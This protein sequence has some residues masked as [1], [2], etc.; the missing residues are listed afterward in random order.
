MSGPM[1]T[2]SKLADLHV[3]LDSVE[4]LSRS[5]RVGQ[6]FDRLT[7]VIRLGGGGQDGLGEDVVYD[8]AEQERFRQASIEWPRGE[9]SL[10][11]FSNALDDISLFERPPQ[12]AAY[13]DY[14]RW[15]IEA[16]GLDLALRQAGK[17]LAE[18]LDLSQPPIRFV[19]S[20]GLGHPPLTDKLLQLRGRVP[21]LRFKLDV[22]SDWSPELLE[23]LHELDAVDVVDFKGA[24][25]GTPVDTAPDARL[26]GRVAQALP[27]ALLEDPAWTPET[28][29]ALEPHR[30]RVSWDAPIHSVKDIEALPF[31]P[32]VLNIKPSRF[33]TIERLCEAYDYCAG[34]GIAMYGGGQFELDI[35]RQQIQTLAALF[36]ADGPNDVS[37]IEY[38]DFGEQTVLPSSPFETARFDTGPGFARV[39]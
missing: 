25:R 22:N 34:A 16:A 14:R 29:A 32:R 5:L 7:T 2:W 6:A 33:G 26:Y 9:F 35:G 21:G 39:P 17:T 20:M 13:L 1:N 24:Y 8:G 30:E 38:H 28:A 4:L 11:E 10:A 12:Q 27:A 37:P 31:P 19:A 36:H 23:K 18:Q 15:A 3:T